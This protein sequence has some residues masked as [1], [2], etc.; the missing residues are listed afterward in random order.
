MNWW[1]RLSNRLGDSNYPDVDEV[2]EAG[3]HTF[4]YCQPAREFAANIGMGH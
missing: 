4:N 2:G 1:K 3:K